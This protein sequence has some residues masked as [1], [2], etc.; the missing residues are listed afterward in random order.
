V[1]NNNTFHTSPQDDWRADGDNTGVN[2][3][4]I[5]G[6]Q[7]GNHTIETITP[8]VLT[9]VCSRGACHQIPIDQLQFGEGDGTVPIL[10][11]SR[12]SGNIDLNAQNDPVTLWLVDSPNN[13]ADAEHTG[14]TANVDVQECALAALQ[15]ATARQ[16]P[17]TPV[18]RPNQLTAQPAAQH[19]QAPQGTTQESPE[20]AL[21]VHGVAEVTVSDPFG[22]TT[23]T[24]SGTLS[25]PIPDAVFYRLGDLSQL[26]LLPTGQPYTVTL[27]VG[28]DPLAIELTQGTS[29]EKT[30]A[31][32][33]QDLELP[34]GAVAMLRITPQ[35][36]EDL[37]YDTGGNG[38]FDH[39]VTP[40]VYVT[41]A[42][43]NDTEPPAITLE[44]SGPLEQTTVTLTATDA[45]TG[46]NRI[47]YS[48]DGTNF[49]LY[50][51]P[52]QV[53]TLETPVV[54]AFADDNVANRSSLL[55]VSLVLRVYLPVVSR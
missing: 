36:V 7:S 52:F 51:G 38:V 44:R 8:D 12:I 17:F 14:M 5:Y 4:H 22:N 21:T 26:V 34:P 1:I 41:G 33:Y 32:R 35:E 55:V 48:L 6:R 28:N 29:S 31:V 54:Y 20:Y 53:N 46:V 50:T 39:S 15:P 16:C 49:Q 27:R 9:T 2:Y 37:R 13:T 25:V 11:A 45:G 19:A 47:K 3:Y 24:L 30:L 18:T 23:D 40:T 43:A 10:S 42:A